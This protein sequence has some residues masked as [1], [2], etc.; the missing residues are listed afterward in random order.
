MASENDFT[1]I[2]EVHL[3]EHD[4]NWPEEFEEEARR[5][6]SLLR[7]NALAIH[8]IGSTAVPGLPAKPV[9]DLMVEVTDLSVVQQMTGQFEEAGYEVLGE[10]GI[11]GRHFLT[12]NAGGERTHDVHIFQ[13]GHKE[14]E[15]MILFR[16]RLRQNPDVAAAY[17]QLK[18]D[19]ANKHRYDPIAYTQAKSEFIMNAVGAQRAQLA[20]RSE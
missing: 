12:R 15:Q 17:S 7:E 2:T 19:L 9:V 10:S 8:H 1:W 16:D 4:P 3:S 11:P 5:L 14:I 6:G 20:D 18:K 13:T